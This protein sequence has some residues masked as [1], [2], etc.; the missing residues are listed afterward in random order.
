MAFKRFTFVFLLIISMISFGQPAN[1]QVRFLPEWL[2]NPAKYAKEIETACNYREEELFAL[3][4]SGHYKQLFNA[5]AQATIA[6]PDSWKSGMNNVEVQSIDIVFSKYPKQ[7]E[8]WITNYYSLLANRLSALFAIDPE[9]N[10]NKIQFNL[11][12][13]TNCETE[14]ATKTLFHGIVIHFNL[15]D[16]SAAKGPKKRTEIQSEPRI[17]PVNDVQDFEYTQKPQRNYPKKKEKKRTVKQE[18]PDFSKKKVK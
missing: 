17:N 6:N 13:Q 12:V 15:I 2:L 7:K 9:L 10:S 5:Y 3:P 4:V 1:S 14:E 18:C 11:I 16:K 8:D